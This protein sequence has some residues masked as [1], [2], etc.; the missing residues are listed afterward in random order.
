MTNHDPGP[1]Q[2][3]GCGP[4]L[5]KDSGDGIDRTIPTGGVEERKPTPNAADTAEEP[6]EVD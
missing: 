2:P 6:A 4:R 1:G 5:D 3:Y